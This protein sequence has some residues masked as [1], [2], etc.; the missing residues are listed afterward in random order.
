V[1]WSDVGEMLAS[2]TG[3]ARPLPSS[4]VEGYLRSLSN[5]G[6]SGQTDCRRN[7]R[8]GE[9]GMLISDVIRSKGDFVVTVAPDETVKTLVAMLNEHGIGAIVVSDDGSTIGGIVSERDVVRRLHRDGAAVLEQKVSDIMTAEVR[10]C[11]PEDNLE[12]TARTM[13]DLRVRHLPV[14]AGGRLR[15]IISIGDVVKHRIDELQ[16]ERQQLVD[17]IQS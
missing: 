6:R 15:A 10:T 2:L 14:V 17:Y 16:V 1:C 9:A 13:T 4:G 12:D 5:H 8:E 11:A 7:G 3:N